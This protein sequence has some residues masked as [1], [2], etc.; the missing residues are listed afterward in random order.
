MQEN[1][2]IYGDHRRLF[3]NTELG[4]ASKCA[5]CYLPSEGFPIGVSAEQTSR[6]NYLTLLEELKNDSRFIS[7]SNGTLISIGCFSECWDSR[8]RSDTKNLIL[9]LLNFG[10]PIQL[11]TKRRIK[12]EDLLP[13][14]S[15]SAWNGQL[16]IYISTATISNWT[17]WE[18]GTTKPHQR[19]LSFDACKEAGI[20]AFLYIKPV[21]PDIT[22]KDAELYAAIMN[23][24]KVAAI[25]GERFTSLTSDDTSP[26]SSELFVSSHGD[27]EELRK[28]LSTSGTVFNSS[29]DTIAKALY[30][31]Q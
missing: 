5:Y 31:N 26:I 18:P 29:T 16:N 10:N 21:I 7:G 1:K 28:K 9:E 15:S 11:A 27:V 6:K 13:I 20:T 4:C 30:G 19:F 8:N 3:I 25:V 2:F 14:I 24:F 22:I 12:H 23:Q 17:T